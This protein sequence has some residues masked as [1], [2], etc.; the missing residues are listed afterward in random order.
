M[1]KLP[2]NAKDLGNP[3]FQQGKITEKFQHILERV[4]NKLASWKFKEISWAR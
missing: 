3:L 1:K 4:E 2:M